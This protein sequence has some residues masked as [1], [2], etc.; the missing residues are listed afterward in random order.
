MVRHERRAM[1]RDIRARSATKTAGDH[2][3]AFIRGSRYAYVPYVLSDAQNGRYGLSI[4]H[5][6]KPGRF[7][8]LRLGAKRRTGPYRHIS[9]VGLAGLA[10]QFTAIEGN[11][12][13]DN[14]S[15]G[16]EI[17]RRTR[18]ADNRVTFIRVAE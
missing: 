9:R 17:M 12:S 10:T 2:T 14:N 6:P 7:G 18:T 13:I 1:V 4:T 15:N 11:T 8:G 16:G 5:S 3:Q